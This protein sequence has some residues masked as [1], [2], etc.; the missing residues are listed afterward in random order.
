VDEKKKKWLTTLR[1]L[2]A[3]MAKPNATKLNT[4]TKRWTRVDPLPSAISSCSEGLHSLWENGFV[5]VP[6]LRESVSEKVQ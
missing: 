4:T 1:L 6:E 5:C 3:A 2:S